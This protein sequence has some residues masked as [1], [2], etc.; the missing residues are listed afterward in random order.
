MKFSA[1]PA[2]PVPGV[3][4][5]EWKMK[6]NQTYAKRPEAVKRDYDRLVRAIADLELIEEHLRKEVLHNDALTSPL[7]QTVELARELGVFV[8]PILSAFLPGATGQI[9][10]VL[11]TIEAARIHSR[12][13][14][15]VP[16]AS[17]GSDPQ[18]TRGRLN[19]PTLR[20]GLLDIS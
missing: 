10:R 2:L 9:A 1:I 14:N 18:E 19:P 13:R 3:L 17:P 8:A 11:S 12:M 5:S 6:I 4:T 16:L 15:G 20:G 7:R